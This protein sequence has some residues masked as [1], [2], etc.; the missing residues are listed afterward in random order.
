MSRVSIAI[1]L[2]VFVIFCLYFSYINIL[3][4]VLN[5]AVIYDVYFM[6]F[7]L[8]IGKMTIV[9]IVI[10]M[11]L[12]NNYL[13]YMYYYDFFHI[14]KVVVITQTSD[15]YQYIAGKQFGKTK[16]GRISKNK[17]YEGYIIGFI[18]TLVT[19][20]PIYYIYE[21]ID[22]FVEAWQISYIYMLGIIGG[23]CSSLFKRIQN[24]KDYSDLLGLH[25]GWMDRIDSIILPSLIIGF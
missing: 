21:L 10:S 16:I 3:Y 2:T 11:L 5:L 7:K 14:I 4:C 20:L 8:N 22:I 12:F 13:M 23:L 1:L 17:T 9:W 25:G 19:F 24:I 15:I 18:F 6:Y